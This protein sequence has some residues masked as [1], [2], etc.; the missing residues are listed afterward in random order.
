MIRTN[1]LTTYSMFLAGAV[2]LAV[3]VAA[4]SGGGSANEDPP[5]LT[6]CQI[7]WANQ[8]SFAG[9][10][11]VYIIDMPIEAWTD[12]DKTYDTTIAGSEI[13]AIY[14]DEIALSGSN[15]GIYLSRGITTAGTFSVTASQG[16]NQGEPVMVT[17]DGNQLYFALNG[18]DDIGLERGDGGA[19]AFTGVW[20]DPQTDPPVNPTPGQPGGRVTL[21]YDTSG[22][23]TRSALSIGAFTRYAVCYDVSPGFAPVGVGDRVVKALRRNP[24][25]ASP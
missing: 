7:V 21:N 20:S 3:G 9:R 10:F 23:G 12:G 13:A 18:N 2:S 8:G 1:R 24:V 16:T 17:D 11:D 6:N 19:A 15:D 22:N 14:Y 5:G 25:F 4:C